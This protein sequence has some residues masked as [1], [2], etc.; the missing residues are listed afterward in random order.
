MPFSK[1]DVGKIETAIR[2]AL[3]SG[4]LDSWQTTFLTD[5]QSRFSDYG[6]RTQLS[7]KQY[8]KLYQTIEPFRNNA[9]RPEIQKARPKRSVT[10]HRRRL[11]RTPKFIRLIRYRLRQIQWAVFSLIVIGI[12]MSSLGS[13]KTVPKDQHASSQQVKQTVFRS[14]KDFRVVDGDTVHIHGAR[15][16][17][18]LIGFNTPETFEPRCEKGLELGRRATFRLKA[19]LANASSVELRLAACACRPGTHGSD[20]C[21]YGRSCGILLIDKQDVGDMLIR[22]GLAARFR[23]GRTSCPPTP[24][25]WCA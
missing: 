24:R 17:T 8:A 5:M 2:V 21:N 13:I 23:C 15:K 20:R 22:E 6:T 12:L 16:S 7:T 9:Y 19:L 25:P 14:V 11:V 10:R 3:Q 1:E 18:R 4:K